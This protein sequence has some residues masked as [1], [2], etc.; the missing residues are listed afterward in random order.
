MAHI[1]RGPATWLP[2]FLFFPLSAFSISRLVGGTSGCS[3]TYSC[4]VPTAS[5]TFSTTYGGYQD[6]QD[7]NST[8]VVNDLSKANDASMYAIGILSADNAPY[9]TQNSGH[10]EFDFVKIN[11]A[12]MDLSTSTDDINGTSSTAYDNVIT[13]GYGFFYQVAFNTRPSFLAGTSPAA[14]F[15]AAMKTQLSA[16]ALAGAFSNA[17]FP[18]AAPGIVIDAANDTASHTTG[19]TIASRG[20]NSTAPLQLIKKGVT[21]TPASDPL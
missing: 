19:V 20:G 11:G 21:I 15:A 3:A 6:I 17:H 1:V 18:L 2:L 13:G 9:A 5:A 8:A 12:A 4:Y 10:N 14:E 16:D 7:G